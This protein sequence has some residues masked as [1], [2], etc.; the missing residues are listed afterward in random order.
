MNETELNN[1][2]T[3]LKNEDYQVRR[4]AIGKLNCS[5]HNKEKTIQ[6]DRSYEKVIPILTAALTDSDGYVGVLAAEALVGIDRNFKQACAVTIVKTLIEI[7]ATKQDEL[8]DEE[9]KDDIDV[10]DLT[11]GESAGYTLFD[12]AGLASSV[13]PEIIPLFANSDPQYRKAVCCAL[14]SMG[15]GNGTAFTQALA[16]KNKLVRL[17]VLDVISVFIEYEDLYDEGMQWVVPALEK[18]TQDENKQVR[19]TASRLLKSI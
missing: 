6:K 14:S 5:I 17:G 7:I 2:K 3:A 10:G 9:Q 4:E 19:S 18:A 13:A 15:Y 11:V 1:L 16:D 12:I 8:V